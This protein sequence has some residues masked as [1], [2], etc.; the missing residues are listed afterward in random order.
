[1]AQQKQIRL[2]TM[3]LQVRSQVSLSRLRIW[4]CCGCGVGRWL[5]LPLDPWPGNLHMAYVGAALEMAKRQKKKK[6]R[7]KTRSSHRGT[8]E[9]NPT[10]NH[11]VVGSIPGLT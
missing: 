8:M 9:T 3:R 2:G 7:R 10:R 6:L 5:Q 11:E 4:C 1:M